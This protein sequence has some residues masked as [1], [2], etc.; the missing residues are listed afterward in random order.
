MRIA[1]VTAT[2]PPYYSGTGMVGYYNALELARRGHA[3]AVFTAAHPRGENE[4]PVEMDVRRL[5]A[6]F[7]FGNAP[8]L[9]GLL[10]LKEFDIIHLHHPFIFGPE[11]VLAVSRSRRI[12]YIITHHNDLIGD[13]A[14]R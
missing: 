4:Y 14:R 5:P 7:R 6:L 2:F 1:D 13:G 10:G 3:V 11:M 12:P 9:P 8:V